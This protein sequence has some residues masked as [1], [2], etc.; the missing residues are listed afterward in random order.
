MSTPM[1]TTNDSPS[2]IERF[3]ETSCGPTDTHTPQRISDLEKHPL[4]TSGAPVHHHG[5]ESLD[6]NYDK[7]EAKGI[8]NDIEA[9][10][11]SL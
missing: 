4:A 1:K 2:K 10:S 6:R 8:K 9:Q 7:V 5:N 11:L 3:D